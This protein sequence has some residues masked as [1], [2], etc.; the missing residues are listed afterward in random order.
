MTGNGIKVDPRKVE[1]VLNWEPPQTVTEVRS[2]LGLAGY[3]WRFIEAFSK[4]AMPLT[5]LLR[6]NVKFIWIEECQR[7]FNE[8]KQRLTIAPV[9]ALPKG[10]G[11]YEV[12]NDASHQG[13]G[14]VLMQRGRVI[15]YA[16]CQLKPHKRNYLTHDLELA[17]VMFALKI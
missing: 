11:G 7:S 1:A 6:K 12:Y 5:Q 13:L 8:L 9:L 4:I 2:F 3:Y 14:C 16:S 10:T 17:A 15:A